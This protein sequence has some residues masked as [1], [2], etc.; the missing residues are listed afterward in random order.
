MKVSDILR[1]KGNTLYTL[2]PDHTLWAAVQTMAEHDI[3][4]VVVMEQG[5]LIGTPAYMSPEQA[6]MTSADIDTRSDIYS[7]GVLLYE[8]LSGAT[9]FDARTLLSAGESATHRYSAGNMVA[10]LNRLLYSTTAGDTSVANYYKEL[11]SGRYTVTG[12]A[13]DWVQVAGTGKS[14]G[15][16]TKGDAITV[17]RIERRCRH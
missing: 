3:G 5:Q 4:S 10:T 13:E 15:D 12:N 14:Y 16:N 11:S 7:L 17:A 9:P 2:G 8:L 6:G 1:V